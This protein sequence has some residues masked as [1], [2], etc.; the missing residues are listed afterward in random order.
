MANSEV[1]SIPLLNTVPTGLY[2]LEIVTAQGEKKLGRF[3]IAR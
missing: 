2:F 1:Q 3:V